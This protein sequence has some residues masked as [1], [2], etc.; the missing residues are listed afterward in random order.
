MKIKSMIMAVACCAVTVS[1]HANVLPKPNSCPSVESMKQVGLQHFEKMGELWAG[2]SK[3]QYGTNE[4]WFFM[5]FL[6]SA[7]SKSDAATEA[8]KAFDSLYLGTGP[9]Y[10]DGGDSSSG[11]ESWVCLY[12]NPELNL[13]VAMTPPPPLERAMTKL[14]LRYRPAY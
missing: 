10:D 8:T 6:P 1:L 7:N 11:E 5:M 3:N 9:V 4:S 12:T 13:G 14:K 2:W